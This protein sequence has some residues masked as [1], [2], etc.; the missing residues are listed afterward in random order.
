MRT[1]V[2]WRCTKC[3]PAA[4]A[5]SSRAGATSVAA[6]LVDTSKARMRVPSRRGC[7]DASRPAGPGRQQHDQREQQ[8]RGRAGGA[9][10]RPQPAGGDQALT[11]PAAPG[12]PPGGAPAG[13]SREHDERDDEQ[14]EQR[15][16]PGEGHR[17]P[18]AS[19]VGAACAAARS[20]TAP[21]PGPRRCDT[22]CRSS[23]ARR[24]GL[25]HEGWPGARRPGRGGVA[26]AGVV[27]VDEDQLAGLGVLD[28]D[29]PGGG[30]LE[31]APVHHLDRHDVVRAASW[32]ASGPP[33]RRR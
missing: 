25:R 10:R 19:C 7:G 23:P 11:R 21:A 15:P 13:G 18:P 22:V 26:E 12:G 17:A 3:V 28:V 24:A 9:A 32:P 30:E 4:L 33:S 6:M 1:L 31:L 8:Q 5:A 14:G 20:G 2:G 27:G 16:R 29:H